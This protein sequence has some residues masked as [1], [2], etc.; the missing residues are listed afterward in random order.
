M[1][2]QCDYEFLEVH[3]HLFSFLFF[4][5]LNFAAYV[6]GGVSPSS[7]TTPSA[8]GGAPTVGGGVVRDSPMLLQ[9]INDLRTALNHA[10]A[11]AH[12]NTAH[13]MHRQLAALKPIKVE[14]YLDEALAFSYN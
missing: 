1:E 5:S 2:I 7:P 11:A 14:N 13:R 12:Y 10:T 4:L 3:Y 6:S 8:A 9:Q